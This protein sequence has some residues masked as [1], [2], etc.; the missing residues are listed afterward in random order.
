MERYFAEVNHAWVYGASG[1]PVAVRVEA[2]DELG[3][4]PRPVGEIPI[5]HPPLKALRAALAGLPF[6]D[7]VMGIV[8]QAYS[9]GATMGSGFRTLLKVLLAKLDLISSRVDML[10][11]SSQR[12]SARKALPISWRGAIGISPTVPSSTASPWARC[13]AAPVFV[14]HSAM[15][16]STISCI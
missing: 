12:K 13:A 6:R 10:E 5:A 8:D 16:L 9:S 4:K 1:E 14:M 7:E 15:R 2:P 11:G 3:G